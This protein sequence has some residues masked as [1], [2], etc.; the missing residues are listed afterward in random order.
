MRIHYCQKYERSI[1]QILALVICLFLISCKAKEDPITPDPPPPDNSAKAQVWL[2][3]GDKTKLFNR[4]GDLSI[5]KTTSSAWPVVTVDTATQYQSVEGFGAALTGSAAFL[6]HNKLSNGARQT[7]L[8]QLF[9]TVNGIGISYLRLTIGASDFSLSN[10]TYDDVPS[11]ETDFTLQHFSQARDAEDVIPMMKEILLLSPGITLLGSPW[12]PPAWMKT[13]SSM[14]GGKLRTDCYDVYA[15][16]FVRYIQ[17]MKGQGINI[18]A[19]TPQNEPL[20]ATAG[21][22][23]MEM[24][25]GEQATFIKNHLGPKF[26][27]AGISTKIIIYDHNWDNTNFAISILNDAAAKQYIAGSAFH[28][29]AGDVSAMSTVHFAHPDKGLYFTEI[30]GGTW[31]TNFSDNLMWNMRNIFIGSTTNWSKCALMWN[32]ALDQNGAPHENGTS[33]CRGVVTI[34]ASGGMVTFNEEYY[35]IAHFSKFVRPGAVRVAISIPAALS[36]IGIVAFLNPDG[37]KSV[38]ACNYG[39]SP[40]TFSIKQGVKNFSY[41]LPAKSVASIKW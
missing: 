8:R 26:Q 39:S 21:Y 33:T 6:L 22:P 40:K 2:T 13:N 19:I 24:Q 9:D 12:S 36:E 37:S 17:E 23:C 3:K 30:S 41:S 7:L 38:I 1:S 15:D 10:Y 5:S 29:Y 32:L 34:N 27:S 20:Y 14:M 31:A 4:E 18:T 25:P 35:S 11:G 16:Y 28:A